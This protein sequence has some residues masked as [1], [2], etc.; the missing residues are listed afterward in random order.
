MSS[1]GVRG[2]RGATTVSE[3]SKE[4]IYEATAELLTSICEANAMNT[5]DIASVLFSMTPDLRAAFPP[6]AARS[7]LGWHDVPLFAM[8]E[9]SVRDSLP[10][11]IRVLVNWNTEKP[12]TQIEHVYLR[13]AVVLRQDLV[14]KR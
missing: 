2:V 3:D 10:Q 12:Q 14:K 6:E 4:A 5:M 13:G 7:K 11:C 9:M 1:S 8:Q